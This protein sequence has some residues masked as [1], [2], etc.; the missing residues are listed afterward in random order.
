VRGL[1]A[2]SP[3]AAVDPVVWRGGRL[4]TVDIGAGSCCLL[5]FRLK[6]RYWLNLLTIRALFSA[7]CAEKRRLCYPLR[8]GR[9]NYMLAVA[10]EAAAAAEQ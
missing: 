4:T 6:R 8:R 7:C 2:A 5:S 1:S 10:G 9:L 3:S